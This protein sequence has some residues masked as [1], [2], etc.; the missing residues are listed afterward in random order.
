MKSAWRYVPILNQRRASH[1]KNQVTSVKEDCFTEGAQSNIRGGGATCHFHPHLSLENNTDSTQTEFVPVRTTSFHQQGTEEGE[2][3]RDHDHQTGR[4]QAAF[5][6][7]CWLIDSRL[8]EEDSYHIPVGNYNGHLVIR[9]I[10]KLEELE[11][12]LPT[13]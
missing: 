4:Y 3:G 11:S 2:P 9:R 13:L 7:N 12:I 6:S 1:P 8:L 5:H 10:S